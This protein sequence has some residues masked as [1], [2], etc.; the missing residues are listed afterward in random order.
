MICVIII[1]K[2]KHFV[3]AMVGVS[4]APRQTLANGSPNQSSAL[5]GIFLP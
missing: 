3:L 2:K 4:A 1:T 5:T